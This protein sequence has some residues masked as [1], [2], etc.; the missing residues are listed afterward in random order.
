LTGCK[1]AEETMGSR[2]QHRTAKLSLNRMYS[3]AAMLVVAIA[4]AAAQDKSAAG[5]IAT[6]NRRIVVSIPDR[7]LA[8]V[9]EGRVLRVYKVA[10]GARVSPSP[11]GEFRVVRR[12]TNP[13]Y[14]HPGVVIPPGKG[15]PLGTRW[16]GLDRKGYGIH[17]TNEPRSIGK[18]A[19]HGCIRMAKADLEQLFDE[20]RVGDV[21]EIHA[22]ADAETAAIFTS[23]RTTTTTAQAVAS[24]AIAGQM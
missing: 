8:L 24:A 17:G 15:N 21:V 14:Y 7:K 22:H 2:E 9:E 10:V 6:R 3:L 19:S 12:L 16:I 13:T 20:A 11:T 4:Q 5:P 1:A 23:G 18:A